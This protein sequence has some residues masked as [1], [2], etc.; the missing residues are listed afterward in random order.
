MVLTWIEAHGIECLIAYYVFS[1][2]S[3][4]MPTPGDASGVAYRWIFSSLG[5][6]NGNLARLIATQ[7]P[8][9]KIGQSLTGNQPVQPV[10]VADVNPKGE[11]K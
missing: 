9:S 7:F 4:G 8:A 11:G 3:G 2:V 6:L 1:A 5:I 10:V